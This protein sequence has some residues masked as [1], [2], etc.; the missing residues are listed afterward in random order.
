[1]RITGEKGLG[2]YLK[3]FL[4]VCFWVSTILLIALPFILGAFGLNIGA[5]AFVIY[6]NGVVLLCIAYKFIKLFDSLKENNPFCE[7]N[8]KLQKSASKIALIGSFIWLIDLLYE[9]IL[10]KGDDLIFNATLAFLCVLYLGVSIAL[11]I[12]SELFKQAKDFKEEN[13]LTI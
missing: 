10:A 8:V 4:E 3:I 1:M 11:Y 9:I 13:E 12:L 7:N 2:N 5:S 6:P